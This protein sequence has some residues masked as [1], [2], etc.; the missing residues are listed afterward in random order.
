MRDPRTVCSTILL[1]L[2]GMPGPTMAARPTAG[3]HAA[4]EGVIVTICPQ[5]RNDRAC[6][7]P[8]GM[9]RQNVATGEVVRLAQNCTNRR[10]MRPGV[11]AEAHT[12]ACY[13]D[14]C[15]P[16]GTYRYGYASPLTCVGSTTF[17]YAEVTVTDQPAK[18][19][20]R[21]GGS[22]PTAVKHV[23]WGS[24]PYICVGGC[25]CELNRGVRTSWGLVLLLIAAVSVYITLR[26]KRAS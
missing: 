14:E 25:G 11:T 1:A 6:P 22:Q 7:Q 26:M 2:L 12:G 18:N 20:R 17:Y 23:P 9:L 4:A 19:C 13:I 16:L 15:V 24:S 10:T 5:L 21:S 3:Y 8:E